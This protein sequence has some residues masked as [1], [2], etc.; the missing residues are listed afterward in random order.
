M[1]T[2]SPGL[3]CGLWIE[4]VIGGYVGNEDWRRMGNKQGVLRE[5]A[6]FILNATISQNWSNK[7]RVLR[8]V[9][10][11]SRAGKQKTIFP[12]DFLLKTHRIY[13]IQHA[14]FSRA[15]LGSEMDTNASWDTDISV[16]SPHGDSDWI[17][18]DHW[19]K[20][21]SSS[22]MHISYGYWRSFVLL[23]LGLFYW[24]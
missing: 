18:E 9:R 11:N 12:A 15:N 10:C 2:Q 1:E 4:A 20:A 7:R 5:A 21:V 22:F 14:A 23:F 13:Q 24:Q 6:V 16:I 8:N 3:D 17:G 19:H